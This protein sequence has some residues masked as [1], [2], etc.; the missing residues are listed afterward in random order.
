MVAVVVEG[1]GGCATA[2][3]G[4]EKRGDTHTHPP[5]GGWGGF[6]LR[7]CLLTAGDAAPGAA[8]ARGELPRERGSRAGAAGWKMLR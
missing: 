6:A 8:H 7:F 2:N 4:L 3:K 5:A 1:G